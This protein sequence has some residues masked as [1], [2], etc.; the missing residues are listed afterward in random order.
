M[1]TLEV[2]KENRQEILKMFSELKAKFLTGKF[3][4]ANLVS[5]YNYSKESA[6]MII[7]TLARNGMLN[8]TFSA[9][10]TIIYNFENDKLKQVDNLKLW[11]KRSE[12][13][14]EFF[15]MSISVIEDEIENKSNNL[16]VVK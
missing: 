3:T 14:I 16:K 13:E 12:T 15:K 1:Y 6:Q 8:L 5:D 4:L 11:L 7:D 9:N 2:I 10:N